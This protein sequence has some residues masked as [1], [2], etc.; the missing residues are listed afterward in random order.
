[1]TGKKP[2][3]ERATSEVRRRIIDG[4]YAHGDFLREEPLV[5]QLGVS[6]HTLRTAL[7]RLVAEGFLVRDANKGV[8][9]PVGNAAA[10]FDLQRARIALEIEATWGLTSTALTGACEV[11]IAELRALEALGGN[12]VAH[13]TVCGQIHCAMVRSSRSP[14][15]IRAHALLSNELLVAKIPLLACGPV[16]CG[17]AGSHASLVSLEGKNLARALREHLERERNAILLLRSH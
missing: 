12:A 6:R 17:D 2:V 16:G 9:V 3:V 7:D 8:R 11:P 10:I 13:A 4:Q 15:L 14:R 5:K 1:M